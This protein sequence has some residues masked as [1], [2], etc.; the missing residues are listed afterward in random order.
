MGVSDTNWLLQLSWKPHGIERTSPFK[1]INRVRQ[2]RRTV[3]QAAGM[4]CDRWLHR[5]QGNLKWPVPKSQSRADA[6]KSLIVCHFHFARLA[7]LCRCTVSVAMAN[8]N[9]TPSVQCRHLDESQSPK[10]GPDSPSSRWHLRGE[11][12]LAAQSAL[13]VCDM[14]LFLVRD[15]LR[16]CHA[17]VGFRPRSLSAQCVAL[18]RSASELAE[19]RGNDVE[20][21]RI[22]K[23]HSSRKM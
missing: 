6:L 21:W 17:A 7:F 13:P 2:M 9:L 4:R 22:S 8:I 11:R 14:P 19:Y 1:E 23:L 10:R 16:C 5:P 3:W 18:V 15:F 20:L 12:L